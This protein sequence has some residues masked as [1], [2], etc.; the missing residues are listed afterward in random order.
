[1]ESC[2]RTR[3]E[4]REVVGLAKRCAEA[5]NLQQQFADLKREFTVVNDLEWESIPV[6]G[7]LTGKKQGETSAVSM[8]LIAP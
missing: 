6:V 1:M 4:A 7:N 5:L 8:F 3:L 2:W